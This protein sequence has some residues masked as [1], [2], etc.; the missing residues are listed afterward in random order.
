LTSWLVQYRAIKDPLLMQQRFLMS[1]LV[2]QYT[3][4]LTTIGTA[5]E[6]YV[7]G[8]WRLMIDPGHRMSAA[9]KQSWI[10]LRNRLGR[11]GFLA[12]LQKQTAYLQ[13]Q[14]EAFTELLANGNSQFTNL[15]AGAPTFTSNVEMWKWLL[16]RRKV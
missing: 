6:R 4:T 12:N 14:Q 1:D 16:A 3:Q 5:E 8:M 15:L 9:E 10:A 13:S 11:T 2:N 7:E